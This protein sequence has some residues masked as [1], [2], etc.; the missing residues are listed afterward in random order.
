ML[1]RTWKSKAL[2]SKYRSISVL[3]TCT[4]TRETYIS[5]AYV[6]LDIGFG[7]PARQRHVTPERNL[8]SVSACAY[9]RS[10]RQAFQQARTRIRPD[11]T[12]RARRQQTHADTHVWEMGQG[13]SRMEV[14]H[15]VP[16]HGPTTR[17]TGADGRGESA[18]HVVVDGGLTI[19]RANGRM[20]GRRALTVPV[21]EHTLE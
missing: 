14:T 8:Q 4:C 1:D 21:G 3:I 16:P 10:H 18:Q 2:C 12:T 5:E 9:G 6:D 19:R 7:Y 17:V 20:S 13:G 15:R 11:Q